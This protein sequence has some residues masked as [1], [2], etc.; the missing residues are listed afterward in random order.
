MIFVADLE[1]EQD[2]L[3][4]KLQ[5]YGNSLLST[6]NIENYGKSSLGD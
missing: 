5:R 4:S 6:A 1:D 2:F 3:L